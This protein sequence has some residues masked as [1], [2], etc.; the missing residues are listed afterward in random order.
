MWDRAPAAST[1]RQGSPSKHAVRWRSIWSNHLLAWLLSVPISQ[2]T[3]WKPC[4]DAS[5]GWSS[6]HV[7]SLN[8]V[9]PRRLVVPKGSHGVFFSAIHIYRVFRQNW[10]VGFPK[11]SYPVNREVPPGETDVL[12]GAHQ[13]L[14]VGNYKNTDSFFCH[15]MVNYGPQKRPK[16]VFF[17]AR[18]MFF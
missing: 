2:C 16:T 17:F 12:S 14:S 11:R 6:Q 18:R 7:T 9:I 13:H 8:E 10:S 4:F 1:P 5:T 3:G 15:D